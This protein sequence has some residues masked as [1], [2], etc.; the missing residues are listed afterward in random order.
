M[1]KFLIKNVTPGSSAAAAGDDQQ[2][3]ESSSSDESEGEKESVMQD[4]VPAKKRRGIVRRYDE[5]YLNFGFICTIVS[6]QPRP[7]CV[8]CS[9]V[10]S[11]GAMN[12]AKLQRHLQ[13]VHPV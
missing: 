2:T 5:K 3:H 9:V 10:L 11:N 7:Q 4:V 6:G 1:D 12:P 8:I 13:T